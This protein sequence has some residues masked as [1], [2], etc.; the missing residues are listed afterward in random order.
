MQLYIERNTPFV[1]YIP[2][3]SRKAWIVSEEKSAEIFS[4]VKFVIYVDVL[5]YQN[6]VCYHRLETE[7]RNDTK[8]T[9]NLWKADSTI[10]AT[11]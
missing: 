7:T 5:P 3:S 2:L 9:R 6:T 4:I 10:D 8:C 11:E 1:L